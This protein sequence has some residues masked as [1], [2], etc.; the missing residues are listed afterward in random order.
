[1]ACGAQTAM[2]SLSGALR[3][4]PSREGAACRY[5]VGGQRGDDRG[6]RDSRDREHGHPCDGPPLRCPRDQ[7]GLG[8]GRSGPRGRPGYAAGLRAH[9]EREIQGLGPAQACRSPPPGGGGHGTGSGAETGAEPDERVLA[10][11]PDR[12]A[13]RRA[14]AGLAGRGQALRFPG[15]SGRYA[16]SR[17]SRCPR[18]VQGADGGQPAARG[19]AARGPASRRS[20]VSGPHGYGAAAARIPDR[21]APGP[22]SRSRLGT[23]RPSRPRRPR[24][25]A[26]SAAHA[27]PR[28]DATRRG[29]PAA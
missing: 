1:M 7:P 26:G 4:R 9:P 10:G 16:A 20:A 23:P 29:L 22:G 28:A 14:R 6:G 25:P 13:P 15:P 11:W 27:T 2:R 8:C 21:S 5:P 3:Y 17:I 19:P 18:G 12:R 24:R